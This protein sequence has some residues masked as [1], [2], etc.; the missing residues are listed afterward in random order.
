[1]PPTREKKKVIS[2]VTIEAA[3]EAASSYAAAHVKLAK[4]EAKMNEEI[5]RVKEKYMDEVTTLTD[6]KAEQFCVLESFATHQKSNWGK[7]KSLDMLHC[8][9]GFR[10]ATPSVT[11]NKKFTWDAVL[12][13]MKKNKIFSK[14]VRTKEEVNKEAI[15]AERNEAVLNQLKEECYISIEQAENFFVEPKVEEIQKT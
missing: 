10:T 12:T 8:I 11:K 4:V 7:K 9:I 1:M 3:N 13:L 2:G 14:F 6:E 5:N 15:L